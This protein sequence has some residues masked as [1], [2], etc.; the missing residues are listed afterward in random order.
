MRII[1]WCLLACTVWL[2]GCTYTQKITDGQTAFERKQFPLA[3]S[4]LQKD[5][6]KVKSRVEKGKIAFLIGESWRMMHR[7]DEAA[8]WYRTAWDHLYGV[9][10]LKQY[11]FALKRA[12]Q[13]RQAIEAFKELGI[14]I[15]SPYEY[16]KEIS[17]C[18]IALGWLENQDP[19]I[20]VRAAEF[21][22]SAADYAPALWHP[23]TLVFTSD[24]AASTGDEVYHW[25][26]RDF[27]DLFVVSLETGIVE[28]FGPPINTPKN[29]G[30]ATFSADG[31]QMVF[32]RCA[33]QSKY[34]DGYCRLYYTRRTD[35]G[36]TPPLPLPFQK[37]GVNYGQ[38]AFSADG[39]WLYFSCNDPE[40]W[41][42]YDIWRVP[43][44]A[45]GWGAPTLLSRAI[46]T[47]GNEQFPTVHGDT[48]YFASDGLIGMGGLD[49]FRSWRMPDGS[50]VPARNL[51]PPINSSSD[52]F[53]LVVDPHPPTEEGWQ[54]GWFSSNRNG[55]DDI[56]YFVRTAA[57]PLAQEDQAELPDSAYQLW[58]DLYVLQKIFSDPNDP[59]SQYLGR[60]PIPQAIL[61]MH[62]PN[63]V[64]TLHTDTEGYIALPLDWNTEYTFTASAPGF[65]TNQATFSTYGIARDPTRPIQRFELELVLERIF[66]NREIVLEDIYYDFDR[67]EI[68]DDAKPTLDRLAQQL[69]LNPN[70]RIMLASHTDCR[71][72]DRYNLELSQK[73]A[74]A[75]V[76][77]LI[78]K[79]VDPDR[80]IARGFGESQPRVPCICTRCTEEEHQLNR[81]TTFAIIDAPEN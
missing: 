77:Y 61:V 36:W 42:G 31:N 37:S 67:W 9:E 18:Q 68:R 51:L 46:N 26:G 5:F 34:A 54:H 2:T 72:S 49:I 40:G 79:G 3:I 20:R 52:D 4:L 10:A 43:H 58:L 15:G 21:N 76:D 70:I 23:N 63:A 57:P 16:R 64:D 39:S 73:R 78:A 6:R 19:S 59:T 66:L 1:I 45:N 22:S 71:G 27:S 69:K 24:R 14:E 7:D 53:A 47:P 41:G 8:K 17:A 28:P 25:T 74:Q 11:A 33:N 30:T 62:T 55:N 81:R 65:L 32:V 13:Y 75:A 35:N 50:W 44:Q 56:F 48:L 12:G 80:L 29:E 38:P 60:K